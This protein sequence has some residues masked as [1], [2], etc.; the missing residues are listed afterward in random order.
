[1]GDFGA[2]I[3]AQALA[4]KT[5]LILPHD[6]ITAI[7]AEA[8]KGMVEEGDIVCVTEAVVARSQNRY[9]SCEDL[10]RMIREGFNLRSQATL[11]VVYPIASRNRFALVLRAIAMATQGGRVIVAFPIPADEV[12]NQVIDPELARTRLSLKTVYKHLSSARGSTPHLN[13]LIR[14]VIAALILQ[15]LGYSIMGMRKIL[16]TGI[17][18]VTVRT[19]DGFIAPL[20]VTFTDHTKA[21]KKSVEILGDMPEARKALAAG[22]DLGRK[23]F[24]LYDALSYLAGE[25]GPLYRTSFAQYLDA[26]SDDEAIYAQELMNGMFRHPI[27]GLDYR[28]LYLDIIKEGGAKGD[29]IFTNNPF[30]VYE[31]GYLDGIILGEVHARKFRKDLFLAFG[32]QAPVKT[33]DE[34]GPVPWGVIGSNVS[35]Y[36]KGVLKLLPEDADGTAEQIRSRILQETGKDVDV[37]IFGDG[38]YKDPDTGIYELADPYPALGASERLREYQLRTGK[39]LKLVVDT[40]YN[41]GYSRGEIERIIAELRENQSDLGTTPRRLASIAATLADLLAGSADQGTP[42]VVIKGMK[43]Q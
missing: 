32:A 43:R 13:I 37:I 1:M 28:Q 25:G 2:R 19:P 7:V 18:D 38:A 42:I 3:E 15:S 14:E 6:D 33:L 11:A 30:K 22:V 39:K 10:A 35:D 34:L 24:V 21:A 29:V 4:I 9:V 5:G 27:T 36:E 8:V 40:L 26:F 16:G 17:A 12:G 20:E 31:L 23:E 41:Q